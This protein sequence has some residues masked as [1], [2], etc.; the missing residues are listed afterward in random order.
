MGMAPLAS[1]LASADSHVVG[2]DDCLQPKVRTL[3]EDAGVVIADFLFEEDLNDCDIVV[4]SSALSKTHPILQQAQAKGLKL[5]R[6]GELLAE[7]SKTRRLVAI[8]G[9]HGKTTT[10]GM[11][12]HGMISSGMK[13]DYILGG[14]FSNTVMSAFRNDGT[15][16]LVAEVDESDGTID[17]FSPEITVVLN[18]DWDHADHYESEE[19][20]RDAFR[21]LLTRTT[22]RI[23]ISKD[24]YAQLNPKIEAEVDFLSLES[25]SGSDNSEF[26]NLN[27]SNASN[28]K[29]LL[30][31]MEASSELP[32]TILDTFPGME[33]RQF[34]L[35][36]DV[37]LTI[38]EDYAHH[39][40]EIE[41]VLKSLR[42]KEP[43]RTLVVVF[44]AH[45]YSRTRQF[46]DELA[47]ALSAADSVYL[48]P[49]YGAHEEETDGG[50][51]LNLSMAFGAKQPKVLPMNALGMERIVMSLPDK[52]IN[53]V[54]L[55]AGNI[56]QFAAAFTSQVRHGFNVKEAWVDYI[57]TRVSNSCRIALDEPLANKTTLR[58][59][60]CASFYAEPCNLSDLHVLLNAAKLFEQEVF[61]LG[62]GSN[63][64]VSDSGFQGLVIRLNKGL[65]R[66]SRLL[67]DG[68]IW[69]GAGVRLKEVCGFAAKAGLAGFEFLE[70]IPGSVGGSLRMNAGAMGSWI[71]DV[72]ERVQFLDSEGILR[73]LP[74]SEFNFGYRKVEEI[75]E[76][77]A[78]GAILRSPENKD[79]DAIRE[80][81]DSY[82]S[83]RKASQ[84]REPSAGCIFKNPEGNF[85]GKL[86]DSNGLKGLKVGD[87]EVS[88][89]HGNFIINRG[90]ATSKDM[91]ELVQIIRNSVLKESGYLLE[92]EVLLLGADWDTLLDK[93][94]ADAKGES[95]E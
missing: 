39:P 85:A 31:A 47:Q 27:A 70:G 45:R 75:S 58:V 15:D 44:Q 19:A 4:Y 80:C 18:L 73:D 21:N 52:P 66:E 36:R 5:M 67:S 26:D 9:S 48:L 30:L 77:M 17:L 8:V 79:R 91:I 10:A 55:G 14:L 22:G 50:S 89:I 11:A 46:K 87:A 43:D 93:A 64:I 78:L 61:T 51:L 41:V 32:A 74:Q 7:I 40:T 68:R 23:L 33:R 54:F 71:F 94:G 63:L 28:A 3:L 83:A 82:A 35:H 88:T 92:P 90:E 16:W 24:L 13:G 60:G 81:M 62:R 53:L 49:V 37:L 2:Y 20:L 95:N 34:C 86:I 29:D 76:G 84:P 72:V 6:R 69:V 59:G 12:A 65:W 57:S 42:K 25:D 56:N 1:W 38:Y